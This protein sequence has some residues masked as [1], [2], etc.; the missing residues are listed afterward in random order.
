MSLIIIEGINSLE[1]LPKKNSRV[2]GI[3][4]PWLAE[5]DGKIKMRIRQMSNP[6]PFS[7]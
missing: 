2:N 1:I 7:G 4:A 5:Y 6:N 3:H